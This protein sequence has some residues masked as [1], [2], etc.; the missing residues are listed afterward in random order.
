MGKGIIDIIVMRLLI[1]DY[2]T[3]H[4]YN[5]HFIYSINWIKQ[6]ILLRKEILG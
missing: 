4:F 1:S 5:L 2:Y 3:L 6:G